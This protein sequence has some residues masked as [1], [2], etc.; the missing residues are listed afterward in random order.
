MTEPIEQPGGATPPDQE[1]EEDPNVESS[2]ED[3]EDQ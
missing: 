3:T 1:A 2:A